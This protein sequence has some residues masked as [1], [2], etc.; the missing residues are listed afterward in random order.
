[1]RYYYMLMRWV[2]PVA[3]ASLWLVARLTGLAR[4]RVLLVAQGRILLVRNAIGN[5]EWCLPG[6]GARWGEPARQAAARELEEEVGVHI[7][8]DRLVHMTTLPPGSVPHQ[9]YPAPIFIASSPD[10]PPKLACNRYEI[11]EA[12]WFKPSELPAHR[13]QMIDVC[14]IA[15]QMRE[16]EGE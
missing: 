9:P 10:Q 4:P 2:H 14:L 8:P 13:S 15:V 16:L 12:G 1:M 11:M 7:A 3:H 6:G 5:Q